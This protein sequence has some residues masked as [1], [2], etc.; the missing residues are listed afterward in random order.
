MDAGVVE[1]KLW[2]DDRVIVGRLDNF[3]NSDRHD[4]T[5]RVTNLVEAGPPLALLELDGQKVRKANME[6]SL[7][8]NLRIRS[9]ILSLEEANNMLPLLRR[10]V[11]D[12]RRTWEVIIT[13]R[14]QLEALERSRDPHAQAQLEE[15]K[16]ELNRLIDR[17]NNYIREVEELGCFVEEFKRG[18][19]NFPTLYLGRK[20]FF[21]WTADET[22]IQY[23]HEL[24]E[25]YNERS[26]IRDKRDFLLQPDA[27][28]FGKTRGFRA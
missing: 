6:S 4:L 8:P 23:W 2:T 3:P 22:E 10:V 9:R 11:S 28:A 20:V 16:S 19:I 13:R 14:T 17:I 26:R 12:I 27:R 5:Q 7:R 25:S 18:V 15:E 1:V 24:D 21:C